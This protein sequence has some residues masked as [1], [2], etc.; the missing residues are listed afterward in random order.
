MKVSLG[1][2]GDHA[3]H[4]QLRSLDEK[5]TLDQLAAMLYPIFD[6]QEKEKQK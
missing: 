3:V 6:Q 4:I 2:F 5:L 1:M